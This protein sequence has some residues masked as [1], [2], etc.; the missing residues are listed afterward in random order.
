[1]PHL[2]AEPGIGPIVAAQPWVSWSHPGRIRSET[3]SA[4]PAGT[5]P[6]PASSGQ[7]THL[8]LDRG[9]DRHLD[10]ALPQ[11]MMTRLSCHSA[12]RNTFVAAPAM[13]GH[14]ARP[15]AA[16]S[17]AVARHR[18]NN[19]KEAEFDSCETT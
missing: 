9:G 5:S 10:R 6:L 11:V 7:V 1:M 12:T 15:R 13:G 14:S 19:V 17:T 4:A 2:L 16:S 3:A 8:R 18:S